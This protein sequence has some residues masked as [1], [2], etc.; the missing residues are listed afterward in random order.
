MLD[1]F[2]DDTWKL[3][4]GSIVVDCCQAWELCPQRSSLPY[5]NDQSR[6]A[7][8]RFRGVHL[9]LCKE[10]GAVL[11]VVERPTKRGAHSWGGHQ[12][13]QV[14]VAWCQWQA[15]SL[16]GRRVYFGV[17]CLVCTTCTHI[18]YDPPL[19]MAHSAR[20]TPRENPYELLGLSQEAANA[21]IRTAYGTR[22]LKVHLG[23]L[24]LPFSCLRS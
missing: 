4:K 15:S 11:P 3:G 7:K 13:G 22:S 19:D 5:A 8:F 21:D 12:E 18:P 1:Y 10:G 9:Y 16:F 17:Q 24:R 14:G 20:K 2:D 6:S 23:R